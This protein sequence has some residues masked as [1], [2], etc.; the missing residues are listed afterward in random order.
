MTCC[1]IYLAMSVLITCH[2]SHVNANYEYE[3]LKSLSHLVDAP[4]VPSQRDTYESAS[5][6]ILPHYY[7]S[8]ELG[9]D[10]YRD[11][12][13]SPAER[14]PISIKKK[15][16]EKNLKKMKIPLIMINKDYTA[17]YKKLLDS[18][19]VHCQEIKGKSVGKEDD[20]RKAITTCYKCEDPK[21]R[22]SYERC[23]H[24]SPPK[25]SAS[26]STRMKRFSSTSVSPRYRRSNVENEKIDY[27]KTR[28]PYRFTDEYFT[29]ATYGVPAA[30]ESKGER[31]V[32]IVKNSM[33]CMICQDAKTNGKYEQCSYVKQPRE[34]EKAYA[35]IKSDTFEKAQE[36]RNDD[37]AEH[38]DDLDDRSNPHLEASDFEESNFKKKDWN[39]TVA[40]DS[41]E[42][43]YPSEDLTERELVSTANQQDTSKVQDAF[44]AACKQ[45]QKDSKTCTVCKDPKIGG[46]YEKCIY[47]Y[48]P[49]DKLYKYSRSKSFGYPDKIS[50][51]STHDL[52]QTQTSEKSK[53]FDYPQNSDSTHDYS[54]K[55]KLSTT[56]PWRYER[57]TDT[58]RE[59]QQVASD[60][61]STLLRD[62]PTYTYSNPISYS[63]SE[64]SST[65]QP[66]ATDDSKSSEDQD[67][68]TPSS[69][70]VSSERYSE[71][72]D[73]DHCKKIQKDSMTCT[74]CKDPKT[75]NN[76]EQCS[77]SYQP[78]D[79]VFSYSKSSSFGN[80]RENDK[81]PR[82]RQMAKT[83]ETKS[84]RAA[85][86]DSS[87]IDKDFYAP[88]PEK[89]YETLTTDEA[90]DD[91]KDGT[92][93]GKKVW[94][95]G[96]VDVGG[97]FRKKD[98]SKCRRIM[99]DKMTCYQC[100]DDNGVQKEEC[101]FVTGREPD[102]LAFREI[103]EFQ[104]NP[105]SH[106]PDLKYP[107]STKADPLESSA[108]ANTDSYV[109]LKKPDNDYTDE[110]QHTTEETKEAEPYD[111]TSETRSRYD[112]VLGLTLPEY[113]FAT[114][115]HE[116]AFDEVVA[117]S[118][119]QR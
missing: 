116:A 90:K 119:D 41:H 77:Y 66:S 15:L 87:E 35:Y 11:R 101:V 2:A 80:S 100:I 38:L 71:N 89:S 95:E 93:E 32:K 86:Q 106:P 17:K 69:K 34:R 64:G 25:E 83:R 111:Y 68:T 51:E 113:M 99:R 29:D 18:E 78:S 67:T 30:Y 88:N 63:N 73:T 79:K 54:D 115:E 3:R 59:S 92:T 58:E 21:T 26:A 82:A 43:S 49:S 65:Y 72:I 31:C 81:Y 98:G 75:G 23:L 6:E 57:I 27:E 117:S 48:Q 70:S 84:E 28:N 118:H 52:N 20:V 46:V 112:K 102:Q 42:Y 13:D 97:Y 22:F 60:F 96:K 85:V 56:N 62:S 44:S 40:K 109:E 1:K 91:S 114:S 110:T 36:R 104:I 24:D 108:S 19:I 14:F 7:N 103:K 53:R 37:G 74:I 4:Q 33:I 5:S 94:E 39:P 12:F 107:S 50:P 76:F 45:V 16:V 10:R 9:Q 61:D 47:N 8:Y 55:S 105:V